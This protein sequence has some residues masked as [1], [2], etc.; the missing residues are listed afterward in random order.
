MDTD[1]RTTSTEANLVRIIR[2]VAGLSLGVMAAFLVS[3]RDVTPELR[4]AFTPWSLVAFAG[5]LG[6]SWLFWRLVFQPDAQPSD[7]LLP[8]HQR[9]RAVRFALLSAILCLATLAA[10]GLSLKGIGNER[11]REV[12]QGAA[13]AVLTL[14]FLGWM[15]W[16]I[17]RFL[18]QDS[19][20]ELKKGSGKSNLSTSAPDTGQAKSR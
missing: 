13:I 2:I 16:R 19:R 12:I 15:L 8:G 9:R 6:F 11:I 4:L 10:F 7:L 3:I 18:E 20:R 5:A 14:S 17:G 1:E